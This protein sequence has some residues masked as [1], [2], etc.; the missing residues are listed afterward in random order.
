V[1][2]QRHISSL[3]LERIVLEGLASPNYGT[4]EYNG[5]VYVH[6]FTIDK[7]SQQLIIWN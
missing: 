7:S 5:I 4:L 6:S 2:R 1:R 3:S